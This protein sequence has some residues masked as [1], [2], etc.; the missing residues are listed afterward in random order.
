ML[1]FV[2]SYYID[3]IEKNFRESKEDCMKHLE[4]GR[5]EGNYSIV[6]NEK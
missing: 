2:L 6:S 4:G 3:Y 1:A 5:G